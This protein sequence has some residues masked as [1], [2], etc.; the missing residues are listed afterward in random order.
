MIALLH[1]ALLFSVIHSS[2]NHRLNMGAAFRIPESHTHVR[3]D[4]G[5][6]L[7]KTRGRFSARRKLS[8]I[9]PKFKSFQGPQRL[10]EVKLAKMAFG[11]VRKFLYFHKRPNQA[12]R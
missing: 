12:L 11:E 6:Y 8:I 2:L 4:S 3:P 5:S 7:S 10:L 1:D 9:L